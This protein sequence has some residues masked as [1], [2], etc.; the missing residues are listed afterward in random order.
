MVDGG[1]DGR[2]DGKGKGRQ[3][4]EKEEYTMLLFLPKLALAALNVGD[5]GLEPAGQAKC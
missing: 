5:L 2:R 4:G 1:D 3:G